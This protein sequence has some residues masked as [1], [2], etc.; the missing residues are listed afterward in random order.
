M[1]YK[2]KYLK[3]KNKYLS[4]KNIQN[5]GVI[6]KPNN[7]LPLYYDT[8]KQLTNDAR[9]HASSRIDISVGL[10]LNTILENYKKDF[11]SY[12]TDDIDTKIKNTNI[13]S[14]ID[15]LKEDIKNRFSNVYS[16]AMEDV[17]NK[18]K[19]FIDSIPNINDI[20]TQADMFAEK[21]QTTQVINSGE[22]YSQYYIKR[23]IQKFNELTINVV[24]IPINIKTLIAEIM[25]EKAVNHAYH[26]HRLSEHTI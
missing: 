9:I 24:D 17:T 13:K 4:L 15:E 12:L 23:Y 8:L 1:S 3:Y 16:Y 20:S 10:D 18:A 2:N 6:C 11:I 21:S 26:R 25:A 7:K 22:F 19:P 14:C 5:G